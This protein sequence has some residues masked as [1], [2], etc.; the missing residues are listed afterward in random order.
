MPPSASSKRPG[1]S[2]ERAGERAFHVA[3]KLAL[4]Q[5]VGHGAAIHLDERR[6]LFAAVVVD[7]AGDEFL[8][9]A[10]F[11]RDEHCGIGG[12]NELNLLHHF[13]HGRDFHR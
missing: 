5:A 10:A 3:E 1:L 12:C 13:A 11:A 8:A 9:R 4:E 7:G 6:G 2:L